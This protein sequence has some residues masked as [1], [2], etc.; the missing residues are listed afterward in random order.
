M[1][2]FPP[3]DATRHSLRFTDYSRIQSRKGTAF[4]EQVLQGMLGTTEEYFRKQ[5][6]DLI[7]DLFALNKYVHS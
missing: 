5:A 4:V 6:L 7:G 1:S 3:L 2:R